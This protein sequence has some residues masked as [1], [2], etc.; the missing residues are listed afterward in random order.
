MV[1]VQ[2]KSKGE[3]FGSRQSLEQMPPPGQSGGRRHWGPQ[4]GAI[5]RGMSDKKRRRVIFQ[6]GLRVQVPV[7]KRR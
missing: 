3:E 1:V 6:D 4:S 5:E 7:F 2:E